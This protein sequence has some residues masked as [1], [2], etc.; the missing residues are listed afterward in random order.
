M[1]KTDIAI[2]I[3]SDIAGMHGLPIP[4]TISAVASEGLR[5]LYE[6]RADAAKTILLKELREGGRDPV[7]VASQDA[8]WESVDAFY[9]AAI[10]GAAREALGLL[11]AAMRKRCFPLT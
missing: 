7:E 8:V 9:R 3:I 11:G 1:S 10:E 5:Q 6:R 2:A 4:A